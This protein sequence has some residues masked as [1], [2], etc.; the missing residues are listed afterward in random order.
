MHHLHG[1]IVVEVK[2]GRVVIDK[3]EWTVTDRNDWRHRLANPF[4]QVVD[5]KMR[6]VRF[7]DVLGRTVVGVPRIE[8]A[9]AFPD[10]HFD[11]PLADQP[12]EVIWDARSLG[13]MEAA[14]LRTFRHWET[15]STHD[16]TAE[17]VQA[18][19]DR[20]A[21][22]LS[23]RRTVAVD[24]GESEAQVIEL[25]A[26]QRETFQILRQMRR[27]VV[28]G[29]AG[30]GKTLLAIEK[31]KQMAS[32]G[33]LVV[34]CFNKPLA[35]YL[36]RE[37]AGTS[38]TALHIHALTSQLSKEVGLGPLPRG[39]DEIVDQAIVGKLRSVAAVPGQPKPFDALIVDEVQDFLNDW[40]D[41]LI[42]LLSSK[43]APVFLFADDH[44]RLYRDALKLEDWPT[45]PLDRNCRNT[46]FIA[47]KAAL[48]IGDPE[49]PKD[50][51]AK[52]V[53]PPFLD[54]G[55]DPEARV[56]ELVNRLVVEERLRPEQI[57]VLCDARGLVDQ[58]RAR[59]QDGTQI[60]E[61]LDPARRGRVHADFLRPY[62]GLPSSIRCGLG[63]RVSV[64]YDP[65][66]SPSITLRQA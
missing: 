6:L 39:R 1:V 64:Q 4:E 18:F 3:N 63:A 26:R 41:G 45:F 32:T 52:G 25:T 9:V 59:E 19:V 33:A 60:V 14:L 35:Q 23:I 27:A 15:R 31:A 61:Q 5:G 16:S 17:Q 28:T 40:I 21:P 43:F 54:I 7:R 47:R 53:F 66:R 2:G 57:A 8:H 38:V 65:R 56:R 12:P 30:T 22:T 48:A 13:D 55:D 20:L 37:L 24:I 29:G 34:T 46:W 44:Q 62:G 58:L 51:S 36:A 11:Q 42:G 50:G 10:I 49:P